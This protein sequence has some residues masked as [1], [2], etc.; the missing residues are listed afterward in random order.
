M[1]AHLNPADGPFWYRGYAEESED[2]I[3][4]DA[5]EV[6]D[7]IGCRRMG[8]PLFTFELRG[9][10]L[11]LSFYSNSDGLVALVPILRASIVVLTMRDLSLAGHTPQP[12]VK[13]RCGNKVF[14]V[15]VLRYL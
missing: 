13:S 2:K 7:R 4:K 14:I 8:A 9:S 12:S 15:S 5:Q 6:L 11:M 10:L 3:C 1:P